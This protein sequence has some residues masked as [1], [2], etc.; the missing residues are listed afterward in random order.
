M[1][2]L[3]FL[4]ILSE[5]I[6]LVFELGVY[7]RKYILPIVVLIYVFIQSVKDSTQVKNYWTSIRQ[8]W[9]EQSVSWV[10]A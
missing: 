2:I 10:R 6:Q 4:D 1:Y 7:T 5:L 9:Q 8:L 3:H